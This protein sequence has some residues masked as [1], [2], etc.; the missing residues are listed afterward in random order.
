M[1]E[2]KKMIDGFI[3]LA[4]RRL[5]TS[6]SDREKSFESI[7]QLHKSRDQKVQEDENYTIENIKWLTIEEFTAEKGEMKIR[8][9]IKASIY[10]NLYSEYNI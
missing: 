7:K 5:E 9:F 1:N 3:D 4:F 10:L 6:M 2:A 8:D